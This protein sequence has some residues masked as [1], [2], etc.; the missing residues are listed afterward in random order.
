MAVAGHDLVGDRFGV[1]VVCLGPRDRER[2]ALRGGHDERVGAAVRHE[3]GGC[4]GGD[5]R[6]DGR[7]AQPVGGA[8]GVTAGER[9][10]EEARGE[11]GGP[12]VRG[13]GERG[14]VGDADEVDNTDDRRVDRPR[15]VLSGRA[16][17]GPWR[18]P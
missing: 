14:E 2:C 12:R 1:A 5:V 7:L 18:H 6:G 8:V 11:G 9:A 15:A 3:D 17:V 10:T 4:V 16:R 13:D